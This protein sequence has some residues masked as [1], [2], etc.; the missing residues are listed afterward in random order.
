MSA[1]DPRFRTVDADNSFM[2]QI[3]AATARFIATSGNP[4]PIPWFIN[5]WVPAGET[6]LLAGPGSGGKSYIALQLQASAA[7]GVPWL[8][9]AVPQC[10]SL[11][12]YSEDRFEAVA[13]RLDGIARYHRTTVAELFA[14]G[15]RVL[16][17][18]HDTGARQHRSRPTRQYHNHR[19][20]GRPAP[21]PNKPR[22]D[23]ADPR[24]PRRLLAGSLLR[25]HRHPSGA[26]A[27]SRSPVRGG[28]GD[29]H[30]PTERHAHGLAGQRRG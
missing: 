11:G 7:L 13:N 28:G 25:Q 10:V 15:M 3:A 17:K 29:D 22:P 12:F 30:R 18:P 9:L 20:V 27:G 24:Q 8:G 1:T 14:C 26:T 5:E 4:P 19:R 16:P 23:A 21:Y 6:T 2:S